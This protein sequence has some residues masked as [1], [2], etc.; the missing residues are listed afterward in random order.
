MIRLR[1]GDTWCVMDSGTGSRLFSGADLALA[2][3]F[4]SSSGSRLWL[5]LQGAKNMQ[6]LS[7]S[8]ALLET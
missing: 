7:G 8:P 1:A 5:W 3:G 6:L 2:P 4:F